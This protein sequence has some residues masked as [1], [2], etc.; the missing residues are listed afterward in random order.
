MATDQRFP[1]G[2]LSDLDDVVAASPHP[3]DQA[4]ISDVNDPDADDIVAQMETMASGGV[5]RKPAGAPTALNKRPASADRISKFRQHSSD[6]KVLKRPG[7][8]VLK[9]PDSNVKQLGCSRCRGSKVG[10]LTC[11]NPAFTGRRCQTE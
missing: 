10:C 2:P 9:R 5:L 1:F 7:S 6:S 4:A 11:R 3:D 8:K